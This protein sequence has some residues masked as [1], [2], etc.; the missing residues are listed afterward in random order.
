MYVKQPRDTRHISEKYSDNKVK[1]NQKS[2]QAQVPM[3]MILWHH[4]YSWANHDPVC[5]L[6]KP[7]QTWMPPFIYKVLGFSTG[8]EE[9]YAKFFLWK[10]HIRH[11]YNNSIFKS[12]QDLETQK[13]TAL[14]LKYNFR[15]NIR[16]IHF[17][18]N[19]IRLCRIL[20][21][22]WEMF[23]CKHLF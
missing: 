8:G 22:M 23:A 11:K 7:R 14:F 12:G 13:L 10:T 21:K 6:T 4:S 20:N 3:S 5:H 9:G 19:F 2:S 17:Y 15:G 18:Y 1:S 16:Y